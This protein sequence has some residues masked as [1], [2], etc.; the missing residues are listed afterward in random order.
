MKE[1]GRDFMVPGYSLRP[2]EQADVEAILEMDRSHMKEEVEKYFQWD[3]ENA[4]QIIVDNLDRARVLV[5]QNRMVGL[6]YWWSEPPNLAILGSIQVAS[7]HRNKGLGKR[8]MGDFEDQ[9]WAAGLRRAGLAVF[10]GNPARAFY[11][12][13]GYRVTGN[14]GPHAWEMEKDLTNPTGAQALRRLDLED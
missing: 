10:T 12:R 11:E 9:A 14:D 3:E 7:G 8:L 5:F 13:L 2:A 4:R 6:Y 1:K